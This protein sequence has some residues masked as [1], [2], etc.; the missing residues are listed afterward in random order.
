MQSR[1]PFFRP[2]LDAVPATAMFPLAVNEGSHCFLGQFQ[3]LFRAAIVFAQWGSLQRSEQ[4][5][6]ER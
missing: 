6:G 5:P 1:Q 4:E 2:R 3:G